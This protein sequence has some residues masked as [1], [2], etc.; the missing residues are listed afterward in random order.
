MV[1]W[2][3]ASFVIKEKPTQLGS[4]KVNLFLSSSFPWN[5][6]GYS[7]KQNKTLILTDVK[8]KKW[9]ILVRQK[10]ETRLETG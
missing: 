3:T 10:P 8:Q 7:L 6:D 2:G 1:S 4:T 9:Q 5:L